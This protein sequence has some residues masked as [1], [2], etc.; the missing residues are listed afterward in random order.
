MKRFLVQ[1][2]IVRIFEKGQGFLSLAKN[3]GKTIFQNISKNL[4]GK[5]GQKLLDNDK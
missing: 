4:S 5:N 3:M 2:N 1:P